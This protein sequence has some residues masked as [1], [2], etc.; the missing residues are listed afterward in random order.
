MERSPRW[1]PMIV[2]LHGLDGDR[3]AHN[4]F[5]VQSSR[6]TLVSYLCVFHERSGAHLLPFPGLGYERRYA[7]C[8]T[9]L[10]GAHRS[11]PGVK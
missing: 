4:V 9:R 1:I 3:R 7:S 2:R 6:I 5:P 8:M 10:I 11:I